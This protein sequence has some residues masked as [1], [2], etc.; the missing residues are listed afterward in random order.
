MSGGLSKAI[1][2]IEAIWHTS[3]AGVTSFDLVVNASGLGAHTLVPDPNVYPIRGQ[4]VTVKGEAKQITTMFYPDENASITPRVGSGISVLGSTY[5]EGNWTPVPDPETTKKIVER[6]KPMAPELLNEQ[7]E[8][9]I[10]SVD[11]AFRPGRKGG[12]RVEIEEIECPCSIRSKKR[13]V[14]HTY[15]H[16]GGGWVC[17]PLSPG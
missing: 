6:C 8:F 5:D 7:G 11:V 1:D 13:V 4:T 17:L 16:A 10:V 9:D 2:A 15:G 12:P 14:C 3:C